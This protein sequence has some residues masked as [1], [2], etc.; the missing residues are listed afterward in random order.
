ML[1]TVILFFASSVTMV[2][3]YRFVPVYATPLMFIRLVQQHN[4]G[5]KLTLKHHWVPFDE[6]NRNLPVAVIASEDQLFLKHNG[7]DFK[8][9]Q[10]AAVERLE[11]KRKR[12]GSTISQ[13]TAKNVFLWPRSSWIRKGFEAYF[14]VLIEFTWSKRRIMEV[15]LNSIEMGQGIYGAGAVAKYK[16]NTEAAELSKGQCALIAASLPNPLKFDSANPSSYMKK[17]KRAILRQMS[18]VEPSITNLFEDKK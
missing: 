17:R 9:I 14:T 2:L 3:L 1:W 13:Q 6:I 16:F 7:F 15:Y 18:N 12:G 5:E 10:N 11:G 4:N 8:Q